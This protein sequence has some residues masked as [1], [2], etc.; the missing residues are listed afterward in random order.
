MPTRLGWYVAEFDAEF[1]HTGS[2]PVTFEIAKNGVQIPYAQRTV[3]APAGGWSV[4]VHIGP[5][6]AE[7]TVANHVWQ[8]N[9]KT[10]VPSADLAHHC[11]T[12]TKVSS[13]WP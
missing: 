8:V 5:V 9:W 1:I 4:H 10:P 13:N 6:K 11:F 7:Q 2:Q 12:V 3:T